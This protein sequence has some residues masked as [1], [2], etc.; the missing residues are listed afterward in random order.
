M[1]TLT[2]QAATPVSARE[3]IAVLSEFDA[4]LFETAEGR[5][6]IVVTLSRDD[7]EIVGVLNALEWYVT[8]RANG[9]A[10][11]ELGGHLY[12]IHPAPNDE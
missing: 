8:E 3:M 4:E 7:A 10:Q 11:L 1:D 5:C 2:I 9:P 6:E 12:V